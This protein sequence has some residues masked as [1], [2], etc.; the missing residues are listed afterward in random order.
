MSLIVTGS[1]GIDT[2]EAPTGHADN[3]LG[4][5]AIYFAAAAS[6]FDEVRLVGAV[7]D[8]FPDAFMDTFHDFKVDL[9]G[10][11]KREG[12]KTFRWTGKYKPTMNDRETLSVELNVLGEEL[13]PVPDHY[14]D[15]RYVFLANTHPAGQMALLEQFPDHQ[16]AVAD[17]MDL[18]IETERKALTDLLGRIDGLVLNDSEALLLTDE[19]NIVRAA[20]RIAE[21]GPTFVVVKKGEHGALLRHQDGYAVFGAYPA[22]N[23]ID[24]TGAGDSF[25][26]GMMGYLSATGGDSSLENLR[27]AIGWGTVVA[28]FNLESFSLER[29]RSLDRQQLEDRFEDFAE[30]T[31]C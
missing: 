17:T 5:S 12:S 7:G 4:G 21:M 2:I 25:A 6:F 3:V 8:D 15:S 29:L 13:P 16:L 31:R 18:W 10:L 14:R 27:K 11:E 20:D 9:D 23:V 1:I 19:E 30:M 28:S 22:R 24:P 26:G